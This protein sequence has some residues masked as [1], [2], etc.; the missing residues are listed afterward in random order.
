M[1]TQFAIA[2]HYTYLRLT[3]CIVKGLKNFISRK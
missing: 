1:Y 2:T 3:P